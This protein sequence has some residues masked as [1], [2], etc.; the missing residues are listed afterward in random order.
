VESLAGSIDMGA[1]LACP[2]G[3]RHKVHAIGEEVARKLS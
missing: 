3:A 1:S 2:R